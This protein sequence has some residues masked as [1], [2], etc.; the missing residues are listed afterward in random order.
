MPYHALF[1]VTGKTAGD[2]KH[3]SGG[4]QEEVC[5]WIISLA[6]LVV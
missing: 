3:A 5:C 1:V 4:L 2:I 6:Y